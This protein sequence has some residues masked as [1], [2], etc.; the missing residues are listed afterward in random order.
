MTY[1]GAFTINYTW[2]K[3]SATAGVLLTQF[4][5]FDESI[6][7]KTIKNLSPDAN[8]RIGYTIPKAEIAVNV[9]YKYTVRRAVFSMNSSLSTGY[10]DGFH[11]VD[12]T[13]S[14]SF[15]K[16]RIQL[17]V[18]GKNLANV[19]NINAQN[20]SGAAHSAGGSGGLM[21]NRGR[22]FFVSLVLQYT[23]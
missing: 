22:T 2:K 14:R 18:G 17:T 19:T 6:K 1:G 8:A 9:F 4:E 10:V 12:I 3:I 16:N 7:E 11:T 15:W 21:V 20:V 5:T 23:K 13:A